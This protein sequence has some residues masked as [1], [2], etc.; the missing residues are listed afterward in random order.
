VAETDVEGNHFK[1]GVD[2]WDIIGQCTS[3]LMTVA[4]VVKQEEGDKYPTI[5]LV[6]SFMNSYMMSLSEDAPI[7]Q[8]WLDTAN[9]LREFSVSSV[10]VCVQYVLQNIR[11]DMEDRWVT[12]LSEDRK[13]FYVVSSLLDPHT[14]MLSFCDNKYF[15]SSWKTIPSVITE[16]MDFDVVSVEGETQLQVYIQVQQVPNDIDPLMWWKQ[17]HQEF[18]DLVRMT[19]QYLAVPVTSES[20]ERFFSRVGLV[21]TDLCGSLLDTTMIDLMWAK[22]AP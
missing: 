15:S 19:R 21:Q 11:E 6:L 4:V 10:Y 13:R 18:P 1:M 20:P 16:S 22:Q 14:K 9:M 2:D 3:S 5:S 7:N 17:H 8:T 12:N